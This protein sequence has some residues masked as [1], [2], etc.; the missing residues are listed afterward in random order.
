MMKTLLLIVLA[1]ALSACGSQP[2]LTPFAVTVPPTQGAVVIATQP[3]P[4][5]RPPTETPTPT[6][7]LTP[8]QTPTATLTPT[9]TFTPSLTPT[10]APVE[11]FMLGR[12][13]ATGGSNLVDRTYPYASTALGNW[14]IHHGVEFQNPRSTVV[15][16]A[17]SGEVYFA[18]QDNQQSYGEKL[19]YYGN[20]V[21]VKHDAKTPDG[22]DLFTVYGHLDRIDVSN[23]QR[24]AEGDTLGTVGA[25]GIAIGPHLHFEVRVGEGDSFCATRNP[26]LW[27]RPYRGTGA[28][29]G[30]L[31]DSSGQPVPE[32]VIKITRPDRSTVVRYAYT[33]AQGSCTNSDNLWREDFATSDLD[34]GDYD[35]I[36]SDRNGRIRFKQTVTIQAERVTFINITLE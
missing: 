25:T 28:I 29:A 17:A 23:G 27:L 12:P 8:S 34:A 32:T 35:V 4:T 24:V 36:V 6:P 1:I 15:I 26:E 7:T 2:P 33:Y 20:V 18:G 13:I 16:A 3:T 11:V 21:I 14:P 22:L 5:L 31:R 19:N 9:Q 10:L 30:T